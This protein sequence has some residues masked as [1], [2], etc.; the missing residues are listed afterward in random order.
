MS[1]DLPA[2]LEAAIDQT[3]VRPFL[4]LRIELPDPVLVWT[5]VGTLLFNDADD[6]EREWIGTGG[7]GSL[8]TI[9]ESTDGSASGIRVGLNQIP[10]EFSSDIADQAER[11]ALFEVYLGTLNETMQQVEAVKLLWKGVVDEYK[12]TDGGVTLAVEVSGESRA[13]DQ[14]RPSIKRFTDEWQK[15]HH[16][17]DDFFQYVSQMPEISI[18]WAAAEQ[19]TAGI[20]LTGGG[21]GGVGSA[22]GIWQR[23]DVRNL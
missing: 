17:S 3:V 7:V 21:G 6:V 11:G 1:R 5:G 12:I 10:A 9:G 4:A 23:T 20:G 19:K 2:A 15:R 13:I 18:L 22:G 14:R 8:D 16:P